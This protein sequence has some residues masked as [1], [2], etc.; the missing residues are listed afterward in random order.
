MTA[1][2][3]TS[4]E[5]AGATTVAT[6][7]PTPSTQGH[8][9]GQS[10]SQQPKKKILRKSVSVDDP[11]D[12]NPT[13][14]SPS[15]SSPPSNNHN[16]LSTSVGG[17]GIISTV[18]SQVWKVGQHHHQLTKS[19]STLNLHSLAG[20]ASSSGPLALGGPANS[21]HYT[22]TSSMANPRVDMSKMAADGDGLGNGN[23]NGNGA[24][25][26]HTGNLDAFV[27]LDMPPSSRD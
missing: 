14:T 20:S 11:A 1:S 16:M 3:A 2:A 21:G 7:T 12:T 10:S 4:A 6:S 24:E 18:S 17:G 22:P 13:T 15:S 23:G 5:L 8:A 25:L 9:R 26:M 27:L 19:G